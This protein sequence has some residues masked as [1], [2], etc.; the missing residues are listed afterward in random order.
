MGACPTVRTT[1]YL[2]E[3]FGETFLANVVAGASVPMS[4]VGP[5][6]MDDGLNASHINPEG[7]TVRMLRIGEHRD[8]SVPGVF[9]YSMEHARE[10]VTPLATIEFA[11]RMLANAATDEETADLLD[12]VEIFV[13]PVANPDGANYSF[14]DFNMQRK[15]LSNHCE[16]A[17]RDPRRGDQWGV[18]L[19]R[20]FAVGSVFDGWVGGSLNCLSG[21]FAGSG[22]LSEP[23]AKNIAWVP[24]EFPNITHSMNV[25]S[26]GG[27]FMWSPGAYKMPGREPLPIPEPEELEMFFD[28]SQRI[29][30]AISLHRGTVTWPANTGPVIDVLYSAG[31]NSADH[32]YYEHDIVAWNFEVGNDLWNPELQRWEAVGFQPPFEEGHPESQEY[33]AGLVELVKVAADAAREDQDVTRLSGGTRYETAV[34]I[35]Q[36]AYPDSTTAVLV[37]GPDASMVD[38]LVAAPLGA[39]LEAPVLLTNSSRLSSATAQDLTDRGV[40]EVVIVGGEGAVGEAVVEALEAMDIEV[41]RISGEN[42]YGTAAAVAELLGADTD[43]V[44]VASGSQGSLVDALAASGP[45]AATGTPVLLVRQDSVPG[46]TAEAL[47]GYGSSVVVGGE[48]VVGDAVLD[49]LPDPV[50]VSGTDRWRTAVA[51]AEHYAAEGLDTRSVV[52]ASGVAA[53]MVDAL[54]GGTL[55]QVVLL[56]RT[57]ALPTSTTGW[58][59]ANEGTEHAYVLGGEVALSE[60]VV[61]LLEG[62]LGGR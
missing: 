58:L 61:E 10:W 31:G 15:N 57:D 9:A 36:E 53:N 21:T 2:N 49:E 32:M 40:T 3:E 41:E 47:E 42:R 35:G 62:I 38:G 46:V 44:V 8:G 25:H 34:A 19:N 20:N 55:G 52:V 23:E 39:A 27:Y 28:A 54:P 22:I 16:G 6:T 29:T 18:D 51:V 4:A 59:E 56:S 11:E 12:T 26:Y 43:E 1:A 33:A 14:Y 48:G 13:L 7:Q 50:R 60:Q 24:E 37:G 45:A 30:E 17:N 5:V